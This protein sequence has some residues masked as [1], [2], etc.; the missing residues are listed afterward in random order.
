MK[1]NEKITVNGFISHHLFPDLIMLFGGSRKYPTALVHFDRGTNKYSVITLKVS[2]KLSP[3]DFGFAQQT[4][5]RHAMKFASQIAR[6]EKGLID[7]Q[8]DLDEISFLKYMVV[9]QG[10]NL[11]ILQRVYPHIKDVEMESVDIEGFKFH[12]QSEK[13]LNVWKNIIPTSKRILTAKIKKL[14]NIFYG[15]VFS[16]PT[17]RSSNV[18]ADY[19][20]STD[21]IRVSNKAKYGDYGV[22]YFIHELGHRIFEKFLSSAKQ[23]IVKERYTQAVKGVNVK[24]S[25]GDIYKF[26]KIGEVVIDDI[27]F[28]RSKMNYTLTSVDDSKKRYT[29]TGSSGF[30][31][32]EPIKVKEKP[33]KDS[34]I[35]TP[36][37]LTNHEE[38]FCEMLG[39]GLVDNNKDVI[40]WFN[41]YIF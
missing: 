39:Y 31:N 4:D 10:V 12:P 40:D 33:T 38:F 34:F 18:I 5:T 19:T 13:D 9:K 27:K 37:A 14:P 36:Y 22:K 1:L 7:T 2:A 29:I 35:L 15:N 23:D 28:S 20:Y 26:D 8:F 24:L 25:K 41:K 21:S 3:Y 17:L 32:A 30:L 6:D 11:S 16:T